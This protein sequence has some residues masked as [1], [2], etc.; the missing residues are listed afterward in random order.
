MYLAGGWLR[1]W[2]LLPQKAANTANTAAPATSPS[3]SSPKVVVQEA[4]IARDLPTG[5][6]AGAI[7]MTQRGVE[8][9]LGFLVVHVRL[10]TSLISDYHRLDAA[11]LKRLA[12]DEPQR[13]PEK[14]DWHGYSIKTAQFRVLK[15]D[16][17]SV[18]PGGMRDGLEG[19]FS[20]AH[21][22]IRN[23]DE[24]VAAIDFVT[25]F[26]LPIEE[27]LAD[28]LKLQFKEEPPVSFTVSKRV[29]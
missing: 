16:G 20:E 27:C 17:T 10:D 25:F 29:R 15:K 13:M 19:G 24:K 11:E 18:T 6:G 4:W 21:S 7:S 28:G 3:A 5:I 1:L 26:I 23:E 14:A 8:R 22:M 12:G 9:G 2:P